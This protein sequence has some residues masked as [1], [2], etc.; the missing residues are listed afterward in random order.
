[1]PYPSPAKGLL[2]ERVDRARWLAIA[3]GFAGVL[4]VVQP[5]AD[6]LNVYAVL[7][8]R[9][10]LRVSRPADALDSSATRSIQVTPATAGA[11]VLM[12]ALVMTFLGWMPMQGRELG[13][14]SLLSRRCATAR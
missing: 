4:L 9:A 6:G 12:A 13:W 1:M 14:L 11:V 3:L 5:A 10:D 7:A 8:R 2:R